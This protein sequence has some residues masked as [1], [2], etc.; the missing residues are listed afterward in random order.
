[1]WELLGI[2]TPKIW[3]CPT[4]LSALQALASSSLDQENS[5]A[6]EGVSQYNAPLYQPWASI[7]QLMGIS[8]LEQLW[9]KWHMHSTAETI[10]A[11]AVL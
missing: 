4:H 3:T 8:Y 5:Y 9:C 1:M 11:K 6:E 7:Y 10:P 2:Q